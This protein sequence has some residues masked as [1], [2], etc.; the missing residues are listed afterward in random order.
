MHEI[1]TIEAR[2]R[3]ARTGA[4]SIES[5]RPRQV[6]RPVPPDEE[7]A[8]AFLGDILTGESHW[9]LGEVQEIL[10][11]HTLVALGHWHGAGLD[12]RAAAD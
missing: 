1:A 9:T 2:P 4:R 11:L 10:A 7:A 8:L 3:R 5:A 6:S 12:G